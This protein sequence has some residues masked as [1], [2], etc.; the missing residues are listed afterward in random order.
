MRLMR[1]WTGFAV[2]IEMGNMPARMTFKFR[3]T[4]AGEDRFETIGP[5][6]ERDGRGEGDPPLADDLGPGRL[7]HIGDRQHLV[8]ELG[9]VDRDVSVATADVPDAM[10]PHP[11]GCHEGD[12]ARRLGMRD[13]ED[14]DA[15]RI[16]PALQEIGW[17]S[18]VVS[19][20]ID[21]HRPHARPV[22]GEQQVVM[23]LEMDGAGVGW[24]GQER[25]GLRVL[26]IAHVE[27]GDAVRIAVTDIGIAA[28]HHDL[29]AVAA[30]ALVGVANELDVAGCYRI[31]GLPLSC[32]AAP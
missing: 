3:L 21:L 26:Q 8:G 5:A 24:T 2:C 19:L 32:R 14:A 13:V 10:W 11:L 25:D 17:R 18:R 9:I 12:L 22:D 30:S 29:D 15:G 20:R 23:G 28:M 6:R 1:Q 7:G 31:H 27:D 16:L 4:A